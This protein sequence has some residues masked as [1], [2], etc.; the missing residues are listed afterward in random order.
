MSQPPHRD[1]WYWEKYV[2]DEGRWRRRDRTPRAADLA[3]M[4]RGLGKPA[5]DVPAMWPFYNAILT[6]ERSPLLDAEHVSLCLYALHQQSQHTPMHQPDIGLGAALRQLSRTK[7]ISE[8]AVTRRFNAAATATSVGELVW[9]LRGLVTQ[10][11]SKAMPLDYT[12]L[13]RDLY[14]WSDADRRARVR[15]RWGM[16]F[17]SWNSKTSEAAESSAPA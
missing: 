15:R 10:L 9:H 4:R 17:H 5:G 13:L 6:S 1:Q 12:G 16:Q 14:A 11:R 7:G 3:A 8:D 2:D